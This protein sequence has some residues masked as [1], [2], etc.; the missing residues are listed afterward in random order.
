MIYNDI[1]SYLPGYK[2]YNLY[3]TE[4][5]DY[6]KQFINE[7]DVEGVID[8][9]HK[10]PLLLFTTEKEITFQNIRFGASL[11]SVIAILGKPKF[12]YY[13][14]TLRHRYE[15]KIFKQNL[16]GINIICI[17]HF[18]NNQLFVI[19]TICQHIVPQLKKFIIQQVSL[20]YALNI[21]HNE[22]LMLNEDLCLSDVHGNKFLLQDVGYVSSYYISGDPV[23]RQWLEEEAKALRDQKEA[24]DKGIII[25]KRFI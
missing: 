2:I 3:R 7:C 15:V 1:T 8:L 10:T 9:L 4:R 13:M 23:Y 12:S 5:A 22:D 16:Q 25:A 18:I 17:G 19:N 21:I 14:D 20:K 6:Y 11:R 24:G